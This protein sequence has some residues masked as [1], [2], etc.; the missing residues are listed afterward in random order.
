MHMRVR[1]SESP[2]GK[3]NSYGKKCF[4]WNLRHNVLHD[5][6]IHDTVVMLYPTLEETR[7]KTRV[8]NTN[9]RCL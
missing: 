8:F 7:E 1:H 5:I 9:E 2:F 3:Q 4:T 6:A